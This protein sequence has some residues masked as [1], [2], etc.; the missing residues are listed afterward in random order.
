[1][2]QK[3]NDEFDDR[4]KRFQHYEYEYTDQLLYIISLYYTGQGKWR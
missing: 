4:K 1:M 2:T 3:N